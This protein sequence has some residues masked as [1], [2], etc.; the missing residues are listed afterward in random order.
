MPN[1]VP[2]SLGQQ[3]RLWQVLA[4]T[5]AVAALAAGLVIGLNPNGL[6]GR[7]EPPI[8]TAAEA[9]RWVLEPPHSVRFVGVAKVLVAPAVN[10]QGWGVQVDADKVYWNHSELIARR[11]PPSRSFVIWIQSSNGEGVREE[12]ESGSWSDEMPNTLRYVTFGPAC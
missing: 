10:H 2:S 6:T 12:G 8:R 9:C 7:V 4:T 5:T 3:P 11:V 1:R